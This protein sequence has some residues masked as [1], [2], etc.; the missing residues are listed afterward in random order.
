MDTELI[1][2]MIQLG[3]GAEREVEDIALTRYAGHLIAQNGDP[4]KVEIAFA[5]TYFAIQR[6]KQEL[7]EPRIAE[8]ERLKALFCDCST[9]EMKKRMDVSETRPL[10]DLLPTMMSKTKD[11]DT[12]I[13]NFIIKLKSFARSSDVCGPRESASPHRASPRGL[14]WGQDSRW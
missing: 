5:Q 4:R 8:R 12:E 1:R 2:K 7:I 9:A 14:S 10:A 6:G 3:K 13:T 11:Y